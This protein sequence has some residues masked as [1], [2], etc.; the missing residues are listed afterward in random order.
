MMSGARRA[1]PGAAPPETQPQAPPQ[2]VRMTLPKCVYRSSR[3]TAP[4]QP[5]RRRD[6]LPRATSE[7]REL[8][9]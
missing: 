7:Q 2:K 5:C 6:R 3:A 9:R 1:P 8:L 4:R